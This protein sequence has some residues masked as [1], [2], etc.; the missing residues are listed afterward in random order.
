MQSDSASKG[1]PRCVCFGIQRPPTSLQEFTSN[2]W[3]DLKPIIASV[4]NDAHPKQWHANANML[5]IRLTVW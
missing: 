2:S 5:E 3:I 1:H 4:Q